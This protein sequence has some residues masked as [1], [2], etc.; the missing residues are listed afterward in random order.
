MADEAKEDNTNGNGDIKILRKEPLKSIWAFV[1]LVD[2]L[3]KSMKVKLALAFGNMVICDRY[4]FDTFVDAGCN[5][6]KNFSETSKRIVERLVPKPGWFIENGQT[7]D[8]C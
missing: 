2:H 7:S 1:R 3:A 4:I 8:R 6:N 5:W